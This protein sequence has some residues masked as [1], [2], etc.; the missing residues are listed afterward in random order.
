M[1]DY[2]L[3]LVFLAFA[4]FMIALIFSWLPLLA[5]TVTS[6]VFTSMPD[7]TWAQATFFSWIGAFIFFWAAD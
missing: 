5:W 1:K 4:G 7:A 6:S 2:L 3:N